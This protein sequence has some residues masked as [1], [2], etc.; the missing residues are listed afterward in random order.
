MKINSLMNGDRFQWRLLLIVPLVV[1]S[2][3]FFTTLADGLS[4]WH[5]ADV[6]LQ[7]RWWVFPVIILV[8]LLFLLCKGTS[9]YVA[10]HGAGIRMTYK[11][12]ILVIAQSVFVEMTMF[13][14][15]IAGDAYK[16]FNLPGEDK[17]QKIKGLL[18]FRV[19]SFVPIIFVIIYVVD[20]VF[21][22]LSIV[23]CLLVLTVLALRQMG[24]SV[25]AFMLSVMGHLAA[26]FC[27]IW[28]SYLLLYFLGAEPPDFLYL[29]GVLVVAQGLSAISNIPFGLGVRE[30]VIGYSFS[31][32]LGMEQMVTFLLL[33]RLTG[34][35]LTALIGWF[36]LL[37]KLL[38]RKFRQVDSR[39]SLQECAT[40]AN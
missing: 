19:A 15:K 33:Q 9:L 32:F 26:F 23:I 35:T 37:P 5:S 20:H 40:E 39:Y 21:V 34:E 31:A 8:A 7:M 10:T 17:K 6:Q 2:L 27:W 30:V 24:Q 29:A 13:P 38:K 18:C 14:A 16:F 22:M 11:N 12:A 3:L 25:S 1:L 36:S 28:Q 4:Q